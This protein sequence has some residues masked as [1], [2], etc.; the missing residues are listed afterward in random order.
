MPLSLPP[1]VAPVAS[2]SDAERARTLRHAAL[3]GFGE[4][5]QR[6]LAAA[7]VAI[8]GA[9]GLGSPA[10][11][12]LAAAGVGTLTVIDDD[13]VDVTNLQ[14]QVLH[15]MSDVGAPK[16]DSAVRVA[17]DL[18]PETRVQAVR[19][20][21]DADCADE[22]LAPADLVLDG[23]D[24]FATRAVVAAA[25]ERLGVPLVWGVVQEFH[26]QVTVF[27]SRPPA[28]HVPVVL[29]DLHPPEAA[30]EAPSCAEV[31][32][33]GALTLQ[34]GSI[35]ATEAIKL[36]TGVGEP[37][38]GRVLLI[39][40]LRARHTEVPLRPATATAAVPSERPGIPLVTAEEMLAAQSAEGAMLLDVREPWETATGTVEGSMLVPLAELLRDPD[41]IE[42]SRPVVVICAKGMR[43]LTAAQALR[44][45]GVEARVLAGGLSAWA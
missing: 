29:S 28:G 13:E 30:G 34:V 32:V 24:T 2:L 14:R 21:I 10:V 5:A 4:L 3:R 23:S 36:L 11:L 7:H 37:L 41:Q 38:L 45:R 6:R 9:G 18:S 8:V 43:A 33:L 25:C 42:A 40:A 27:W 31:G 44:E 26:A 12:A 1:L 20:R 35:M 19:R 39:D 22:L 15:R 17:A 16:T